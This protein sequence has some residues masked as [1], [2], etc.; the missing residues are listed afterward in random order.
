LFAGF[1]QHDGDYPTVGDGN[2]FVTLFA[3]GGT[4]IARFS[5]LS[6]MD[7]PGGF[8]SIPPSHAPSA[9]SEVW[10]ANW[11]N[12]RIQRFDQRTNAELGLVRTPD[13][14]PWVMPQIHSLLFPPRANASPIT[15]RR[16]AR[17]TRPNPTNIII[18]MSTRAG[19]KANVFALVNRMM[20]PRTMVRC[21]RN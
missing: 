12:G 17:L 6:Y 11:A 15:N 8:V 18:I 10:V 19:S 9:R 1:A 16:P 3:P 4:Q 21:W 14:D 2:S 5:G 13:E 20:K 7:V